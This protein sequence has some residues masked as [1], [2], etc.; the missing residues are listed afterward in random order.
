MGLSHRWLW[1]VCDGCEPGGHSILTMY[2]VWA[3]QSLTNLN[4]LILLLPFPTRPIL[5][6]QFS[7]IFQRSQFM[8]SF[9]ISREIWLHQHFVMHH[10]SISREILPPP[11]FVKFLRSQ[12]LWANRTYVPDIGQSASLPS[13][14]ASLQEPVANIYFQHACSH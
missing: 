4:P 6:K 12:F 5:L 9:I 1:L 8:Y 7:G 3:T 11:Y 14:V 2:D 10:S 13:P